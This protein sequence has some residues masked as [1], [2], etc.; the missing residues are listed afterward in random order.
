MH[1]E[2][3]MDN[4]YHKKMG[5]FIRDS[6][7][8]SSYAG[9]VKA[10]QAIVDAEKSAWEGGVKFDADKVRVDLIDADALEELAK[11]LTFGAQKYAEDNWRKG[12]SYRRIIAAA[13]RHLLCI[14]RG[15]DYDEETNLPHAAHLMCCAM[16][17]I[18]MMKNRPDMDNRWHTKPKARP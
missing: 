7:E 12:I 9:V 5:A 16:F 6:E 13:F 1:D 17:L 15:R 4:P 8:G 2:K 11:V 14:M 3:G 18:W 10:A